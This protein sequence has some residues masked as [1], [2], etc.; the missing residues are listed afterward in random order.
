MTKT[1]DQNDPRALAL[2]KA[3]QARLVRSAPYDKPM[4]SWDELTERQRTSRIQTAADWIHDAYSADLG[5]S[6]E[7]KPAPNAQ[8]FDAI[9]T[10]LTARQ[11]EIDEAL[12]NTATTPW[13]VIRAASMM[14][15]RIVENLIT[16][17]LS[18][19]GDPDEDLSPSWF[20]RAQ[21]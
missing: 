15:D 3:R 2:A 6:A 4:P 12:R 14:R 7:H 11:K 17:R 5:V 8:Q 1:G 20:P 13:V 10:F 19:H 21:A 9:Q 16:V 18:L